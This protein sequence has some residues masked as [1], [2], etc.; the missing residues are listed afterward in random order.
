MRLIAD[1]IRHMPADSSCHQFCI[2]VSRRVQ[3]AYTPFWRLF[4]REKVLRR[5]YE[6]PE[7]RITA[8]AVVFSRRRR[9][10]W[11]VGDCQC[12]LNG[13]LYENPKPYEDKLA[14]MRAER[15]RQLLAEGRTPESILACDEARQAIIPAMLQEMKNQNVSYAVIDGFRIPEH[16][17][18]VIPLD[19]RPWD[20]VLASDGYPRLFPT[21]AESEEWLRKQRDSDPLNIGEFKATKG[22]APGNLSFDDRTYIRFS[23]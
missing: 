2:G 21:L 11:M 19:F 23:V 17:V 5:A 18:P 9:E 8:S 20:I 15:V 13:Q 7:E 10:I 22:F 12:L 3:R 16:L 1:Y 4:G 14:Q 6:H